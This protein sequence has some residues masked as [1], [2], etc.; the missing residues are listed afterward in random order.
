MESRGEGKPIWD[1]L[2]LVYDESLW[3]KSS[4]HSLVFFFFFFFICNV[5]IDQQ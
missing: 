5:F 4:T 3:S 1:F 2:V